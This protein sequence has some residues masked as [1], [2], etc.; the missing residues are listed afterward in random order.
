MKI[1]ASVLLLSLA[2]LGDKPDVALGW[3]H[4]AQACG[5]IATPAP[6]VGTTPPVARQRRVLDLGAPRARRSGRRFPS[7]LAGAAGGEPGKTF[8]APVVEGAVAGQAAVVNGR[9]GDSA[10]VARD[11]VDQ[12]KEWGAKG[13]WREA[14]EQLEKERRG[15]RKPV[16]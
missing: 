15:G 16:S 12:V 5:S 14:M 7:R 9:A 1:N 8:E 10:V 3:V 2:L 4:N 13:T 6:A 11:R